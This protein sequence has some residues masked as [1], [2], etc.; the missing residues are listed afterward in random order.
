MIPLK[1]VATREKLDPI[2]SCV[3]ENIK[4][5]NQENVFGLEENKNL[6]ET[7]KTLE[8]IT[9]NDTLVLLYSEARKKLK[10]IKSNENTVTSRNIV[11]KPEVK[12]LPLCS[13]LKKQL[14]DI[15]TGALRKSGTM[16]LKPKSGQS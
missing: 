12:N 7:S 16:T 6:S 13:T 2:Q 8:K 4:V 9:A 15:E 5:F 11:V 10:S 1:V 14:K 3:R